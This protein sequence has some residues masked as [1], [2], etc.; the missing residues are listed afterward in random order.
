ME[1]HVLDRMEGLINQ[2][3]KQRFI[4][5]IDEITDDLTYEGFDEMDVA[6]Y[7]TD[8]IKERLVG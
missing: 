8:I 2:T 1:A 6:T 4:E 7:L 5:L 3:M